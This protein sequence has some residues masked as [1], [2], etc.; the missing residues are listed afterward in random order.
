ME[1]KK[2]E[3]KKPRFNRSEMHGGLLIKR[4]IVVSASSNVRKV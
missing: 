3:V 1:V 4:G 2:E